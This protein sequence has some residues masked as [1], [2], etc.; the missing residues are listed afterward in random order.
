MVRSAATPT[1]ITWGLVVEDRNSLV[2][3]LPKPT[4]DPHVDWM[5]WQPVPMVGPS[6]VTGDSVSAPIDIRSQRRLDEVGQ[7]LWLSWDESVV[8]PTITFSVT[9]IL[10]VLL[11]LP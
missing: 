4:E 7:T 9:F 11:R 3:E 6:G 8:S 10:S 1:G 5:A 2:T